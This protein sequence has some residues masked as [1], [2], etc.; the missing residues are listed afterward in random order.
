MDRRVGLLLEFYRGLPGDRAKVETEERGFAFL[1][2]ILVDGVTLEYGELTLSRLLHKY[3]LAN[4]PEPRLVD[5][6]EAHVAKRCNVCLYFDDHANDTFCL[7]LDNNHKTD[8]TRILPEMALA[9][10]TLR[11]RLT[12]LGCEPL[13]VASGR[14]Y[15]VWCRLGARVEND[16]LYR[17]MLH[18]GATTMAALH[19]AGH[20]HRTVKI[21]LYPD[22]RTR[23]VVS[24][25]L[26]G[27]EHAKNKVFSYVVTPEGPLDEE[28]SWRA[29]EEY[30][31]EK[32]IPEPVFRRACEGIVGALLVE[33]HRNLPLEPHIHVDLLDEAR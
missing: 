1:E 11:E 21:N 12:S 29:F 13:V 23:D 2:R 24:L 18:A 19:H 31:R 4:L 27:S 10:R 14:G 15:H 3:K 28:A 22:I 6:L 9:V 25:R 16:V 20:D 26:F 8:N 17:F 33:P 30:L 7:N 5:L 32:T